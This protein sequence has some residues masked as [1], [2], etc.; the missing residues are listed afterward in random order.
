MSSG[1]PKARVDAGDVTLVWGDRSSWKATLREESLRN[2]LERSVGERLL[3]ALA[4]VRL[5]GEGGVEPR[6]S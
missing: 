2:H 3:A 1:R 6:R 5:G 4:M